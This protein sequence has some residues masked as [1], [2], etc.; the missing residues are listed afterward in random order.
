MRAG[1]VCTKSAKAK[2]ATTT[3]DHS[4]SRRGLQAWNSHRLSLSSAKEAANRVL[5]STTDKLSSTSPRSPNRPYASVWAHKPAAHRYI[6][7]RWPF[8]ATS[9]TTRASVALTSTTANERVG[10]CNSLLSELSPR[11]M[12]PAFALDLR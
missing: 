4:I 6:P 7:S 5:A 11:I 2:K 8:S 12:R 9:P 1:S 10:M 3:G